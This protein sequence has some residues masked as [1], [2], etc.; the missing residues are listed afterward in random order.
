MRKFGTKGRGK[1][2]YK[3]LR[4]NRSATQTELKAAYFKL[5]R[6]YH[7]KGG[8]TPNK[9]AFNEATRAYNLL[10]DESK[11]S[12]YDQT[13][14]SE[15]EEPEYKS[16]SEYDDDFGIDSLKIRVGRYNLDPDMKV[17]TDIAPIEIKIDLPIREM[18]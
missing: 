16:Q 3:I 5:V 18:L 11:R 10:S 17:S 15:S 7:P 12:E 4:A 1:C 13:I 2:Y 14:S 8:A 9:H 6:E